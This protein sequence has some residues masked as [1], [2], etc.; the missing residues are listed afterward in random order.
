MNMEE[1]TFWFDNFAVLFNNMEKFYPTFHMTVVQKLNAIMR[2][3]IYAGIILTLVGQNYLYLYIPVVIGFFT[4]FIYNNQRDNI[5]KLFA[6]YIKCDSNKPCVEPTVENPFMNFN[7]ITDDRIRPAACHSYNNEHVKEKIEDKFNYNLY[8]DV[9]D[10][11]GK[12]NSQREYY[13]MPNTKAVSEQT[14]FAKWLYSTG[15]TCKEDTIKC[16]PEW[17]PIGNEEIFEKYV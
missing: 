17:S 4:W 12:N 1:T 11:Y 13:T 14:S 10:L 15:P 7:L 5:E 16:A 2:L 8:R 6:D 3:A 9:G